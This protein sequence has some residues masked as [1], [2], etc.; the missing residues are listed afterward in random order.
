MCGIAGLLGREQVGFAAS[1]DESLR[2]RGPDDSG[3]YADS[4]ATLVH[5]RL[6]LLDPTVAGHQPMVSPDGRHVIVFNGE[7][8]NFRALRAELMAAGVAFRSGTDT[9]VVLALFVR[10]GPRCLSRLRGMFAFCIWDSVERSAFL[11]RDPLGIKPLYRRHGPDGSLAF[12]S[13][14]RVLLAAGLTRPELDPAGLAHYLAFGALPSNRTLVAGITPLAPGHCA[15]WKDG[16]WTEERFWRPDFSVH[17]GEPETAVPRVREALRASIEAHLVSDVPVGLFLSGGLDSST[18]LALAGGRLPAV[19]IGFAGPAYDESTIAARVAAHFGAEHHVLEVPAGLAR[20]WLPEFLAAMDQPSV[21]GF[22]TFCA[23]RAARER[24]LKAM[25]A[26]SGGDE[27]FGGYPSFTDVPDLLASRRR[28]QPA[29]AR[30]ALALAGRADTGSRRM[31]ALLGGAA[32]VDAVHDGYRSVFTPGEVLALMAGWG[33]VSPDGAGK[34]TD[35]WGIG[36]GAVTFPTELDRVAWLETTNFLG[37][38]LLRDADSFGMAAGVEI[39]V[40]FAD[41]ALLDAVAPIAAGVRLAPGKALLKA[42]LPE[43]PSWLTAL[44]KRGFTVPFADWFDAGD[45][46]GSGFLAAWRMPSLPPGLDVRDWSRRWSL[47][48]LGEWLERHL[49]LTLYDRSSAA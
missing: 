17:V 48:V 44:P 13:E 25:L 30:F 19:S 39:R 9:E 34:A 41:A 31:A 26:G 45:L 36:P 37:N 8:Y 46:D 18:I 35:D 11:A 16:T 43:L 2:H 22:N 7:I 33:I 47:I 14:L 24:G 42:A 38:R 29:A 49:G 3:R 20:A 6:A 1:A 40:P 32:T 12:A 5:R 21:D 4:V 28:L 15:I 10:E 27:L 23:A